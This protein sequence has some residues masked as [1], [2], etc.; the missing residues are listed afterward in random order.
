MSV[1]QQQHTLSHRD[2]PVISNRVPGSPIELEQIRVVSLG[3]LPG[4]SSQAP[5]PGRAQIIQVSSGT[6]AR[7]LRDANTE[8]GLLIAP[9]A[10]S[11]PANST[12]STGQA[13]GASNPNA[14]QANA[15][16]V[17]RTDRPGSRLLKSTV[18]V[19]PVSNILKRLL[20]SQTTSLLRLTVTE[21]DE[22]EDEEAESK[23]QKFT[24]FLR[25][26]SN[27]LSRPEND[28]LKSFR[29]R[30]IEH[31]QVLLQSPEPGSKPLPYIRFIGARN[32]DEVKVLHAS[33]SKRMFRKEYYPPL[34]ICY[35][36]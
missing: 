26:T 7:S 3:D 14:Q 12:A 1:V 13:A 27:D 17:V 34:K 6:V 25:A 15:P 2:E 30:W 36:V 23:Y 4:S 5:R 18:E 22:F 32:E 33:L 31:D 19:N 16:P 9:Q 35:V 28:P 24:D 8:S 21:V 20:T 10:N 29:G 11:L